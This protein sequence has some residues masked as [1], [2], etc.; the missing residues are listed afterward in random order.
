[1]IEPPAAFSRASRCRPATT[2]SVA[3]RSV[4]RSNALGYDVTLLCWPTRRPTA[5]PGCR[6]GRVS[7]RFRKNNK[8][9]IPFLTV[10]IPI[11]SCFVQV[12]TC[13]LWEDDLSE[14][15][16]M[17][18]RQQAFQFRIGFFLG[19]PKFMKSL[20]FWKFQYF[21]VVII[22][23]LDKSSNILN[24]LWPNSQKI[25]KKNLG[26]IYACCCVCVGGGG[27]GV[28]ITKISFRNPNPWWVITRREEAEHCQV[29]LM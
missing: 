3:T 20:K 8:I 27:A 22:W 4:S 6:S 13:Y 9:M 23:K 25:A 11:P 12:V 29:S 7:I 26:E 2:T 18:R 10:F 28:D 5:P 19:D 17:L 1:M 14:T 16:N 24:K 15:C 21:L